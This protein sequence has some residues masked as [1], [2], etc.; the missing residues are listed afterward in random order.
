MTEKIRKPATILL[1]LFCA[2]ISAIIVPLFGL[3]AGTLL[4]GAIVILPFLFYCMYNPKIGFLITLTF[5]S[6]IFIIGRLLKTD[7]PLGSLIDV[8]FYFLLLGIFFKKVVNHEK[9]KSPFYNPIT[10]LYLILFLY[11]LFEVLNPNGTFKGWFLGFRSYTLYFIIFLVSL[12]VVDSLNFIKLFTKVFLTI[13]VLAALYALYQ[14]FAGLPSFDLKYMTSSEERIGLNFIHGRWRKWSFLSDVGAFGLFMSY[15]GIVSLVLALG[16]FKIHNRIILVICGI[17]MLW[18]MI[19]SGTRTAYAVVPLGLGLY[20]LMNITNK[21]ALAFS[22][23]ASGILVVLIFGPFYG[24]TLTRIRSAFSPSDDPSM[25][26]RD[27][28]RQVIQP[29]IHSH[30][31]G[32]GL[33]TT[34]APGTELAPNHPLAGFPPDS[35]YL[36]VALEIGPIGLIIQMTLFLVIL[37]VAIKNYYNSRN[38]TFRIFYLAFIA[39]MFAMHIAAYAKKSVTQLPLG[40][41]LI[42]S[43]AVIYKMKELEY[44]ALDTKQEKS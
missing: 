22:I 8:S 31:I 42:G 43:Y 9:L 4:L 10:T 34:G 2:V 44:G 19:Y 17:L 25:N 32:G 3:K 39:G 15:S 13:A 27:M 14:E 36:E 1:L 12:Y 33:N 26:L 40:I 37:I 5:S 41:V 24:P 29:Y 7:F 6:T 30:P 35:T 11:I 28:N 16:P 38:P 21:K 18:S 20:V 23:I